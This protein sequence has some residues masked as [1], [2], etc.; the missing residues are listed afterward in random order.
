MPV[1]SIVNDDCVCRRTVV[2]VSDIAFSADPNTILSTYAL[3]SCVGVVAY[4][5]VI[6][7]GG[8]LHFMLPDSGLTPDKAQQQPAMFADSGV[9]A[10]LSQ[11]KKSKSHIKNIKF[12]LIGGASLLTENDM[13]KIGE[14]N[15][16]QL[17]EIFE[18][19]KLTL[20]GEETGGYNNR[21]VH[22]RLQTQ[23][24]EIKSSAETKE[25][26]LL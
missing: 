12:F 23:T 25:V 22:F 16:K 11:F 17:K 10:L 21:T 15:L 24:L 18:K 14:K 19:E 6:S 9:N 13:F 2:G 1:T 20:I 8:L 26:S 5:P 3:G 7:L 4:D